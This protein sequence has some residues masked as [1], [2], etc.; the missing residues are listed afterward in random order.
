M[1]RLGLYE[2]KIY[3]M[4]KKIKDLTLE[5]AK[6][7]CDK[8]LKQDENGFYYCATCPYANAK[9]YHCKLSYTYLNEYGNEEIEVEDDE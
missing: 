1:A 6:T 8:H 3:K 4:K 5:E 7:L 9:E 2:R